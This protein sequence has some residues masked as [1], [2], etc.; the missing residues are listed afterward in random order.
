MF[1]FFSE[2]V[3]PGWALWDSKTCICSRPGPS[4]LPAKSWRPLF[5]WWP[6]LPKQHRR[7]IGMAK[8]LQW[9]AGP[10]ESFADFLFGASWWFMFSLFSQRKKTFAEARVLQ[11]LRGLPAQSQKLA[12]VLSQCC[13]TSSIVAWFCMLQAWW[14]YGWLQ[15]HATIKVA[16][17]G[18]IAW[19]MCMRAVFTARAR[20]VPLTFW[21]CARLP[22]A[23]GTRPRGNVAWWYDELILLGLLRL[24]LTCRCMH[25]GGCNSQRVCS[26]RG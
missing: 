16:K 2:T 17:K 22:S 24:F 10:A 8:V 4:M 23:C 19:L 20:H 6:Q 21:G 18:M 5:M 25:K 15:A 9:S 14:V 26:F 7:A 11:L 3:G 12:I 1:S 13:S